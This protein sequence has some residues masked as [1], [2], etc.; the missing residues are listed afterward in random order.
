MLKRKVIPITQKNSIGYKCGDCLSFVRNAK[1][2][3]PCSQLGVK[4]F[5]DAPSCFSPDVFILNKKNPDVVQQLGILLNDFSATDM[6]VFM[7]LLKASKNYEKHYALKFGQPVHF[8]L[9]RDYLSNYFRGFVLGVSEAGERQVYVTSDLKSTQRKSPVIATLFRESVFTNAEFK[10]KR[11][12]L[13]KAK[14]INDPVPL[15]KAYKGQ[16]KPSKVTD[17]YVPPTLED[18]PS[19]WLD[20]TDR[21]PVKKSFNREVD[22]T[23]TFKVR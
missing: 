2:E 21:L 16:P 12:V 14:R 4:R 5:A 20:K 10:K 8:Y 7:A 17:T 1:F 23:L 19:E 13:I 11:E 22:G 3:K 6:R 9:N 15:V 18:A